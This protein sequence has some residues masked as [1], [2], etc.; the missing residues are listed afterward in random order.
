MKHKYLIISLLNLFFLTASA[1]SHSDSYPVVIE[2]LFSLD[3]KKWTITE[4]FHGNDHDL[5][6]LHSKNGPP[7]ETV[8]FVFDKLPKTKLD[9]NPTNLSS[10]LFPKYKNRSS[11]S[12]MR[13][14]HL[15]SK[16]EQSPYNAWKL[17]YVFNENDII[18]RCITPSLGP[19]TKSYQITRLIKK[20][21]GFISITY[22]RPDLE[23][24]NTET[25]WLSWLKSLKIS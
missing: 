13:E 16:H 14:L 5:L 2:S 25:Y 18:Y 15:D 4:Q 23:P 1:T 24:S 3:P 9:H 20:E 19:Y 10:L 17:L 6:E 12:R 7:L 11:L 22:E 8:K 21:E